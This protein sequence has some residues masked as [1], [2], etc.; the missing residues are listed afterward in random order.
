MSSDWPLTTVISGGQTGADRAGLEAAVAS[1]LQTGGT[2]PPLFMTTRGPDYT[3]KTEFGLVE[4]TPRVSVPVGYVKRSQKNIDDS[5]GSL[6]FKSHNSTGTDKSIGYCITGH[7]KLAANTVKRY[8]SKPHRPF[9][10]IDLE[11]TTH[12]TVQTFIKDNDIKTLNVLGHRQTKA[13]PTWESDVKDF[14]IL[15]FNEK[16]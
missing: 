11:T 15:C 6:I 1:G 4:L 9:L 12:V 7:W 2:A 8:F 14:L 3:L 10:I 13:N 16:K 5:D